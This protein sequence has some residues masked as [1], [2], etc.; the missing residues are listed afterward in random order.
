[1]LLIVV[2]LVWFALAT[3]FAALCRV[4]AYEDLDASG[5]RVPSA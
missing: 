2:P 4:A 1:M 3:L 5:A